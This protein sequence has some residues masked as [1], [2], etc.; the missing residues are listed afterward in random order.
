MDGTRV[1]ETG[2]QEWGVLRTSELEYE[3]PEGLIA[4][5][6][7]EPRDSA[8]LLVISRADATRREDRRVSDLPGLLS[9][10]DL[11]LVNESKVIPARVLG[12]RKD[13]GGRVEGLYLGSTE[14]RS[15]TLDRDN[16]ADSG[17]G[18]ESVLA[19]TGAHRHDGY[20]NGR[21]WRL[22]LRGKRMKPG[23]VVVLHDHDGGESGVELHLI[24]ADHAEGE[25]GAWEA[26]A[27]TPVGVSA[28]SVLERI[29]YAPL[30]PYILAARRRAEAAGE[31]ERDGDMK[32]ANDAEQSLSDQQHYQTVYANAASPGSVAAP[33]AGLHFTP[34]LLGSL[35]R[36]GVKRASVTLHVGAGTFKPVQA[37]WLH[38]HPMHAEWCTVSAATAKAIVETRAKGGRVIAVG[39][40]TARTLESFSRGEI[41][42]AARGEDSLA[43]WT[44]IL[45]SPGHEFVNLDGLMTNFHLPRSTLLALVGAMVEGGLPRMREVYRYAIGAGYRF[46][47]YGDAMVILP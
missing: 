29:G 22:M 26:V 21:C 46:Y 47:S 9:A 32:G 20:A 1:G 7:A 10:G 40:T 38:E 14:D 23:V 8:R 25:A 27:N 33:T 34:G 37:E 35:E 6:P 3:L 24:S 41:E 5:A 2:H 30:P 15:R 31:I 45:I 17:D 36:A 11:L 18:I 44:R 12:H 39:T 13:T 42:R 28:M 16:A 43:K 4:T 19:A